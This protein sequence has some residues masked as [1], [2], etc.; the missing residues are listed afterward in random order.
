M[1]NLERQR[2]FITAVPMCLSSFD[3][4]P[5][6]ALIAALAKQVEVLSEDYPEATELLIKDIYEGDF[7]IRVFGKES[8]EQYN[9]RIEEEQRQETKDRERDLATLKRLKAKYPDIKIEL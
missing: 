6:L 5:V 4:E 1:P 2:V 9:R 3:G 8:D 7:E